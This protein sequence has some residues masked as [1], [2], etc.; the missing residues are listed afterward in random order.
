MAR[1]SVDLGSDKVAERDDA[2]NRKLKKLTRGRP[3][4][5]KAREQGWKDCERTGWSFTNIPV[6]IKEMFDA[7]AEKRGLG[8][9]QFL[10]HCLRAGGLDIPADDVLDARRR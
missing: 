6:P 4:V 8:K 1:L 7:E 5:S 2:E 3:S 10:Y 9:K